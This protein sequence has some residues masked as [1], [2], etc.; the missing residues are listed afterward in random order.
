MNLRTERRSHFL[1]ALFALFFL[2]ASVA[3]A[4]TYIRLSNDTKWTLIWC[5]VIIAGGR[6]VAALIKGGSK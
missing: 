4:T 5:A 3:S 2:S 6:I 1:T